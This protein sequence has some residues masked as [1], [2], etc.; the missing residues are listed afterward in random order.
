MVC[1]YII[2]SWER[3]QGHTTDAGAGSWQGSS[4]VSLSLVYGLFPSEMGVI[5]EITGLQPTHVIEKAGQI[6]KREW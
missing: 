5:S 6:N 1:A 3:E 2:Q 4:L